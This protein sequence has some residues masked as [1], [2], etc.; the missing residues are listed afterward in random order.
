MWTMNGMDGQNKPTEENNMR[1]NRIL[2]YIGA[3]SLLLAVCACGKEDLNTT[4][5]TGNGGTVAALPEGTFVVDYS[6]SDGETSRAGEEGRLNTSI[7]S[8]LYLLYDSE[9]Q[10]VKEREIPGIDDN[11]TWPLTRENMSWEQRE[12]LKDT[13][14]VGSTYTAVFLANTDA[15]LFNDASDK[16]EQVFFYKT[17]TE[18]ADGTSETTYANLQDVYLKLPSVPFN[19]KNMFYISKHTLSAKNADGTTVE[20]DRDTPYNCPVTLKRLV[21]RMDITKAEVTDEMIKEGLKEFYYQGETAEENKI[22]QAVE[23]ALEKFADEACPEEE[24][25]NTNCDILKNKLKGKGANEKTV[26]SEVFESCLSQLVNNKCKGNS[27]Y[28]SHVASWEENKDVSFTYTNQANIYNINSLQAEHRDDISSN[29]NYSVLDDGSIVA[30]VF[31]NSAKSVSVASDDFNQLSAFKVGKV[32]YILDTPW[33]VA[34]GPNEM[35]SLSCNPV[36][37]ISSTDI[38]NSMS[39]SVTVDMESLFGNL[40]SFTSSNND[41]IYAEGTVMQKDLIDA[42]NSVFSDKYGSWNDLKLT[43]QLPSLEEGNLELKASLTKQT[44]P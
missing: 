32:Y 33:K 34:M 7:S 20:Y 19:D 10:L 11:T 9:G 28:Q 42:M 43:L 23:T 24:L 31:S 15:E 2:N 8:L 18:G 25:W 29:S 1:Q 26:Y 16:A 4:T 44:N 36:K 41:F 30:I 6:V 37:K 14:N 3:A 13:L 5:D 38:E 17:V 12:A 22:L 21:S 40:N 39:V 35:V 27:L